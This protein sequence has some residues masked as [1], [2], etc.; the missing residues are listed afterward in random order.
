[1]SGKERIPF[2]TQCNGG[3]VPPQQESETHMMFQVIAPFL[4]PL[5]IL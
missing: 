4:W 3:E 1:M 2:K 5:K